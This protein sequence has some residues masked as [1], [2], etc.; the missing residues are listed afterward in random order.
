LGRSEFS[1]S[2]APYSRI[3]LSDPPSA[4]I[5]DA[6]AAYSF[7]SSGTKLRA[8]VGNG[9]RVPSLYER[10]GTFFSTFGTPEFI[11]I[12]NPFLKPEKTLAFDTGIDQD[13]SS[14]RVRL[15]ATYFYTRLNDIIGFGNAVPNIGT[16]FRPFGGYE[17]QKG[18][19]A[20]G[21]EFSSRIRP[22]SSTEI[23]A[24]YTYTN[25]DQRTP[26]VSGSGILTSL[27]IPD[28]QLTLVATQR[29]GRFW[30]NLDFLATS[31]YLAP[32]FSGSTF[33]SYVYR[34][35]GN[36]KADLTAGYTF[37]LGSDGCSLRLFGTIEN[38]FD[39]EYFENGFRTA[40]I[41]GRIG[42]SFAF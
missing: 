41:N 32:I 39:H 15:S 12:G 25:S 18:G 20:R 11:A 31:S 28:H 7:R 23:F 35:S 4:F 29:I 36:R 9:Y 10:F 38:L 24:S 30:V 2:N 8:H 27:G 40:G 37:R 16:T 34:F 22:V 3:T 26:Q 42:L 5:F 21:G 14:E 13:L 17:N 19:I 6:A 1:L 33:T